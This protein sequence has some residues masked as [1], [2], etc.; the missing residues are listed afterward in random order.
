M[1]GAFILVTVEAERGQIWQLG[2]V[3]LKIRSII[4]I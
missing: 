1:D 2:E 4:L 3:V